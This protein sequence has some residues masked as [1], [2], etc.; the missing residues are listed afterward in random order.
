[1]L[2][3]E[4]GILDATMAQN[5]CPQRLE[6]YNVLADFLTVQNDYEHAVKILEVTKNQDNSSQKN[7]DLVKQTLVKK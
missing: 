2:R 4:D 5:I 6:A 7:Y 3:Y 1:M